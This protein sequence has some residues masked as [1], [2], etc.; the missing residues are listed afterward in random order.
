[1]D[2]HTHST[3][4]KRS[5]KPRKQQQQHHRLATAILLSASTL[6]FLLT[7]PTTTHAQK[8]YPVGSRRVGY[9]TFNDVLYIQGGYDT[10]PSSQ[11]ASLD[12][13]T[14]W[15]A[16]APAWT[17]RKNGQA[18]SHLALVPVSAGS[19]GGSKGSILAIGGM[20][21][22]AGP[23]FLTMY[24]IDSASWTNGLN[25]VKA[26]FPT[27]E[28]H[29]AVSDP[30]TGLVYIIGGYNGNS[31]YNA[32]TV[33]DPKSRMIVSQSA[34]TAS[35]S[36]TDVAAVWSTERNSILSF[37]GSRAPPA[38]SNAVSNDLMEYD[39]TS[40]SWK[41]VSTS[42]DVPPARLD[43]CMAVS[44]DGSKIVVFGGTVDGNIYLNTLYILDVKSG[45]WK[46][47]ESAPVTRTRMACA[48]HSY[49]FIA[50]G[51]SSGASRITM[52][53]NT[54]IIY[55]LN[56]GKWVDKY[57]ADQTEKKTSI[58]AIIGGLAAVAALAGVVAFL[59]IRKRKK[60]QRE[61]EE[62][63]KSD[64]LA[65]N[66]AGMEDDNIKVAVPD[67]PR[68]EYGNEYPLNKMENSSTSPQQ[69]QQ[70][71]SP[72]G[73]QSP[74]VAYPQY[75]G[76]H[77]GYASPYQQY[78]GEFGPGGEYSPDQYSVYPTH[79]QPY[80]PTD[81]QNHQ[82]QNPFVSPED[83]HSPAMGAASSVSSG[84]SNPFT[85]ASAATPVVASATT[86]GY[87]SPSRI[88]PAHGPFQSNQT[89]PWNGTYPGQQQM[90]SPSPG[91]R[92]PQVIPESATVTTTTSTSYVP[93]PM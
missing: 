72:Y 60:A 79:I 87:Q 14:S 46:Q 6:L 32:L 10:D 19:N 27:I 1:M 85:N 18:T 92:A 74:A 57:D 31:S 37:G 25:N 26:Q 93:P 61:R 17:L 65:A 63:F 55:D 86:A 36:L 73:V 45:K 54:P 59:V 40:K 47:G 43:H 2:P 88:T 42:G 21:T 91:A 62:A 66:L 39:V 28:G 12:L 90:M 3:S 29:A 41:T 4:H 84:S 23:I 78:N 7:L 76:D 64:T 80:P 81:Y 51:G 16:S 20:P 75:G 89:A 49:Q 82:Q 44:E 5:S 68:M 69:Q 15:D 35:T 67:S 34:G 50:W 71:P 33:Y 58:G 38:A 11:F 13:S 52:L 48:F 53:T 30:N 77:A 83:Y 22:G 24:D 56:T 70:Y 9:T 8:G